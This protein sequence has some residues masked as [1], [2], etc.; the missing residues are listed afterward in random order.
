[1]WLDAKDEHCGN[2]MAVLVFGIQPNLSCSSNHARMTLKHLNFL[3][4]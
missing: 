3:I 2:I 4:D 1:M